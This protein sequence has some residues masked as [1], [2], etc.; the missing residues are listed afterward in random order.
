LIYLVISLVFALAVAMFAV[1]NSY[2]VSLTFF[3]W[4]VTASFAVVVISATILG[5]LIVGLIALFRYVGSGLR[6]RDERSR[7]QRAARELEQAKLTA[8][9]M[10]REIEDLTAQNRKL[11]AR[12]QELQTGGQVAPPVV[13]TVAKPPVAGEPG[14]ASS[15][16]AA[17]DGQAKPPV[18]GGT[19]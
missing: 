2:L 13:A 18:K 5:A 6:L 7:G 19:A 10:R 14:E 15:R 11:A 9:E 16:A 17:T 8:T 3:G 1:Q 12:V 4:E